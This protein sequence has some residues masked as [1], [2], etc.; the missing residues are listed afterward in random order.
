MGGV[1]AG[2]LPNT[3]S[4]VGVEVPVLGLLVGLSDASLVVLRER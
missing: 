3:E 1:G 2:E 4:S